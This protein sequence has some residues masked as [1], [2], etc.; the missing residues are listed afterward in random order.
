MTCN[1]NNE[2]LIHMIQRINRQVLE[3]VNNSGALTY[4][5][6]VYIVYETEINGD[7]ALGIKGDVITEKTLMNPPPLVETDVKIFSDQGILT[8]KGVARLRNVPISEI[9]GNNFTREQLEG[10]SYFLIG[11]DQY[12]IENGGLTKTPSNIYWEVMLKR[13]NNGE[14]F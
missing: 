4:A 3:S 12:S 7:D 11:C 14:K 2:S 5:A 6:D 8:K 9:D 10:A 1:Y 13:K